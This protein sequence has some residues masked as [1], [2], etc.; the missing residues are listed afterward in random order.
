MAWSQVLVDNYLLIA[1]A[2]LVLLYFVL[3]IRLNIVVKDQEMPEQ[4]KRSVFASERVIV[5]S[6]NRYDNGLM[7]IGLRH[8]DEHMHVQALAYREAGILPTDRDPVQGF[9]DNKGNFLT[10]RQ[11]KIVAEKAGQI[12]RRVGGDEEELYSENIY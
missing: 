7:L 11:A 6:A 9:L 1:G 8:W 2:L 10:R 4:I 3:A 12:I 5:T